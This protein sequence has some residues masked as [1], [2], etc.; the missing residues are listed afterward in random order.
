MSSN[1][2]LL[3]LILLLLVSCGGSKSDVNDPILSNSGNLNNTNT[4]VTN[5]NSSNANTTNTTTQSY[6]FNNDL[7]WSDEFDQTSFSTDNWN[8]E[9]VPPNNGSWWNG[10]LQYYTDKEDNL[11]VEDGL[12]KITAKRED[13]EGKLYTS[14]RITTQDKFEFTY[15]RVEMRAKLPN[16]EGMWPA[17]GC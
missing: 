11:K 15:G 12:L 13:Y 16:W 7:V 1:F 10:E 9:T 6:T 5:N 4:T 14:A 17:F 2:H 8:I 3:H